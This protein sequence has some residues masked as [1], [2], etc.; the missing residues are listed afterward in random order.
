VNL[1]LNGCDEIIF[2]HP[3]TFHFTLLKQGSN[4]F[5]GTASI[6]VNSKVAQFKEA[7]KSNIPLSR[8]SGEFNH[9]Q[10]DGITL[11]DTGE[12]I[13]KL[14][15]LGVG[16]Q[17][18]LVMSLDDSSSNGNTGQHYQSKISSILHSNMSDAEKISI[19]DDLFEMTHNALGAKDNA[20]GAKDSLLETK[21]KDIN[22]F[23]RKET[24]LKENWM[25]AISLKPMKGA[26][27]QSVVLTTGRGPRNGEGN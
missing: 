20:L 22:E 21:D 17:N 14:N 1:H 8:G 19:L 26:S 11:I 13:A 16:P 12:E 25:L 9:L 3:M 6:S 24:S 15:E 4:I 18:P 23:W 10:L 5:K 7:V 27:Q 2:F